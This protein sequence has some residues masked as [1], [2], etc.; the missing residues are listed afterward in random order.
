ME[1]G[2]G[3]V[4]KFSAALL[5]YSLWYKGGQRVLEQYWKESNDL[6][7]AGGLLKREWGKD[8]DRKTAHVTSLSNKQ[9]PLAVREREN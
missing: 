3:R 9:T 1:P 8:G 7:E 2:W 4:I 5:F 6:A